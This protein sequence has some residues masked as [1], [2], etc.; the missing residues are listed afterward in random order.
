[1]NLYTWNR[2]SAY[3]VNQL[4]VLSVNGARPVKGLYLLKFLVVRV[5]CGERH[6]TVRCLSVRPSVR[7]SV[8]SI[9][10]SSGDRRV[11]C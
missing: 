11:C 6:K 10:S 5:V 4:G 9:D 7:L 2:V 3:R 1:V 8:P